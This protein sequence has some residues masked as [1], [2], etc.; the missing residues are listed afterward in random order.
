MPTRW[1]RLGRRGRR[2][3]VACGTGGPAWWLGA[4]RR[5]V[6]QGSREHDACCRQRQRRGPPEHRLLHGTEWC[7]TVTIGFFLRSLARSLGIEQAQ[8]K[9]EKPTEADECQSDSNVS[10][11]TGG[12]VSR[13]NTGTVPIQYDFPV[14]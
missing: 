12:L 5:Q 13:A 14:G 6:R 7:E 8:L 10:E 4:R 2:S 1:L 9:I 11:E 3:L